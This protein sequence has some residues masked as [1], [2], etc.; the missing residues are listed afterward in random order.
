MSTNLGVSETRWGLSDGP[1]QYPHPNPPNLGPC[2]LNGKEE[3]AG[4]MKLRVM[5]WGDDP[6]LPRYGQC[7]H[8]NPVGRPENQREGGIMM[9]A[10]VRDTD[11]GR[12]YTVSLKVKVDDGAL[13][14]GMP[15]TCLS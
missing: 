4:V 15:V 5:R 2:P 9:E 8:E 1:Q 12:C 6:G 7:N 10:E 11:T 13:G 14:Q 3:F